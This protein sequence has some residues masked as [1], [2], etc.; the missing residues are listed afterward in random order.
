MHDVLTD[1]ETSR[2][3]HHLDLYGARRQLEHL[4]SA[5]D[6][7]FPK[8]IEAQRSDHPTGLLILHIHNFQP[9]LVKTQPSL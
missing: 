7:T 3:I 8:D 6:S 9:H 5:L 1:T 2:R 4:L